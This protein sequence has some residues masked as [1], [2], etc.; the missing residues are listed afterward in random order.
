[1]TRS[2]GKSRINFVV[3]LTDDQGRWAMP[4]RMPELVMPNLERLLAS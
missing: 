4:H 3:I 1:M 2:V